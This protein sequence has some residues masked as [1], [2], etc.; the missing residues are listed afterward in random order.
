[1]KISD[2]AMKLLK[3]YASRP[4]FGLGVDPAPSVVYGSGVQDG[5]T[6]LAEQ[7]LEQIKE[8]ESK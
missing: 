8:E 1:M 7:I 6:I 2:A 3:E 5:I 4:I